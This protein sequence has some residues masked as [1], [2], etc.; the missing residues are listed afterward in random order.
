MIPFICPSCSFP[1]DVEGASY[2]CAN[3]HCFDIAKEG[4]VNLAVGK[5]DSGDDGNM[6]RARRD[7]LSAGYYKP[8]ADELSDVL[9][10]HNVKSVCDA[11]CG[12]GYYSRAIKDG[13]PDSDIIGLDLAKTSVKL[14]SRSEKGR[15]SPIRYAVAGIFSMPLPDN[16]FDSL[17]SVFAPVPDNEAN[18]ILKNGGIMLV[19]HP[20]KD[21]LSGL[22]S[23]LYENPY[24]NEES[25]TEYEGFE[26]IYDRRV[27]YDTTVCKE[28]IQSLFLMTPYY[29]K[30]SRADAE[31]LEN[32]T[33]LS[34]TLDFI[35]S[36]YKKNEREIAYE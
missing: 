4:Y 2:K 36:V 17:I 33:Q 5:S 27:K 25:I 6:C 15:I 20:G 18:R 24:D 21:H 30:T 9:R 8:L 34:T 12:E 19:V 23:V 32:L 13:L 10:L 1:L 26:H 3:K 16:S 35:I 29:W 7:F 22:K 14:A 11:V 28:H 31:K